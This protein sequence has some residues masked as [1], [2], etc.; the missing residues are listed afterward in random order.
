L[1]RFCLSHKLL[2]EVDAVI[3]EIAEPIGIKFLAVTLYRIVLVSDNSKNFNGSLVR[4]L[5]LQERVRVFNS[6]L[7]SFTKIK[8][9]ANSAFISNSLNVMFLTAITGI[10][11][12]NYF[13]GFN[14]FWL[15][16]LSLL[17]L[18]FRKSR[19]V[20]NLFSYFLFNLRDNAWKDRF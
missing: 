11:F 3:D 7:A 12:M 5:N 6:S 10:T 2:S 17:I 9:I 1:S 13:G 8:I 18:R 20:H 19:L 15:F 4:M 16:L 14:F